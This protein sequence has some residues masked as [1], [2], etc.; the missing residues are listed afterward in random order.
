[1]YRRQ[2]PATVGLKGGCI[3]IAYIDG[4]TASLFIQAI[5]GGMAAVAVLAKIYWGRLLRFLHLRKPEERV[6]PS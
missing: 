2:L 5:A 3:V 1:M 4:G 6:S